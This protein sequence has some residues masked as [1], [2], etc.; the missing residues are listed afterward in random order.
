MEELAVSF[1]AFI[2]KIFIDA[3]SHK[4]VQIKKKSDQFP[5]VFMYYESN[6]MVAYY[7]GLGL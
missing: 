2:N 4:T 5:K 1:S 7:P 3:S 6:V